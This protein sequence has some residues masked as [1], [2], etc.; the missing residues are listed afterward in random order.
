M[1]SIARQVSNA[2]LAIN[3]TALRAMA[4]PSRP[5]SQSKQKLVLELMKDKFFLRG[6]ALYGLVMG[7]SL[8]NILFNSNDLNP[9]DIDHPFI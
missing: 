8:T 9:K 1:L 7:V 3:K 6:V 4:Q 2:S 5:L